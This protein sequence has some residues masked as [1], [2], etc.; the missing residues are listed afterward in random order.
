MPK[1]YGKPALHA[2]N[3]YRVASLRAI[4]AWSIAV[5]VMVSI[6][7]LGG[8]ESFTKRG[9]SSFSI[10]LLIIFAIV[11]VN[12]ARKAHVN[13]HKAKAGIDAE[14][15]VA[16][17][18]RNVPAAAVIHGALLGKGGDADHIVLGPMA[19]L[20]ETKHGRGEV[21]VNASQVFAGRKKLPKD[22]IGQANRQAAA[23]RKKIK[24]RYVQSILCVTQMSNSPF[25]HNGVIV[26]SIKDLPSVLRTVQNH[27]ISAEEANKIAYTLI[28]EPT[29]YRKPKNS[30]SVK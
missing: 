27:D 17:A 16:K 6:N 4:A 1:V 10:T 28:S 13:A 25:Q 18:L 30:K 2:K 26:C 23:L 24:G 22:P 9:G 3:L 20:I 15:Q 8:I 5:L 11:A 7:E 14:N 21:S 12:I 29:P 19:A